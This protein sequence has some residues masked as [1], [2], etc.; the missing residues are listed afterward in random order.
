MIRPAELTAIRDGAVAQAFRRWDR[1][2]VLVGTPLGTGVGLDRGDSVEQVEEHAIGED[3]ARRA[4]AASLEALRR[5]W[6]RRQNGPAH[7]VGLRYAMGRIPGGRS[8]DDTARRPTQA[9]RERGSAGLRT[10]GP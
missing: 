10:R 8:P 5:G 3:D 6:R 4:G 9:S 2:R 1:P 7:R